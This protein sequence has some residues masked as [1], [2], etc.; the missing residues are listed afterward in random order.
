MDGPQE[1]ARMDMLRRRMPEFQVVIDILKILL[2]REGG[3]ATDAA[4]DVSI[5]LLRE[6]LERLP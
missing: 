5:L 6:Q 2:L 3:R 4:D 1:K